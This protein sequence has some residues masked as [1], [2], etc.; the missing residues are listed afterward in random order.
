MYTYTYIGVYIHRC[1]DIHIRV[2]NV[3]E[4]GTYMYLRIHIHI[5]ICKYMYLYKCSW[6]GEQ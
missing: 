4:L 5:C 1:I 3:H 2:V 6:G